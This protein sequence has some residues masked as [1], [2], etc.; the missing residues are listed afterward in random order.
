M[1]AAIHLDDH[2]RIEAGEVGDGV[3]QRTCRRNLA[4]STWLPRSIRHIRRSASVLP[5]R[6]S[7]ARSNRTRRSRMARAWRRRTVARPLTLPRLRRGPL[8]LPQGER[9]AS[10]HQRRWASNPSTHA[11]RELQTLHLSPCGRGRGPRREAAWEGEGSHRRHRS[12]AITASATLAE[13]VKTR[14]PASDPPVS[15]RAQ[16]GSRR[17][18]HALSAQQV[19]LTRPSTRAL[20]SP[21]QPLLALGRSLAWKVR[22]DALPPALPPSSPKSLLRSL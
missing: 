1:L 15:P 4:P 7:R 3:A 14:R 9:C 19:A 13:S 16:G 17:A 11:R 8:P 2:L 18:R 12:A 22:S 20:S 21:P 10:P 6:I 5:R